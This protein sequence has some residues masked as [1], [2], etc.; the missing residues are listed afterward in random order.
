MDKAIPGNI[1]AEA[2]T[3]GAMLLDRDAIS[4]VATMLKPQ[5]FILEKHRWI[6]EAM[7]GVHQRRSEVDLQTVLEELRRH[8]RHTAVGDLAGLVDLTSAVPYSLHIEYYAGIVVEAATRRSII[9]AGGK[10]AA[11]GYEAERELSDVVA[12]CHVVLSDAIRTSV[13]TEAASAALVIDELM[14][15][16]D[17]D[18][19]PGCSSGLRDL[20]AKL[21]GF[22]PEDL[23]IIAARPSVGKSSLIAQIAVNI[24]K[25]GEP[26]MIF[27][28]EMG[29]KK[30]MQ[31]MVCLQTGYDLQKMALRKFGDGDLAM[32][33]ECA[34]L[35]RELP[36]YIEHKGGR[37]PETLRT[38]VLAHVMRHGRLAV[39]MVDYLQLMNG[40]AKYNG[41]RV[42]EV[43]EVS[44]Q[45]K[46]IAMETGIP[47]IALSQL[48]RAVENRAN[49]TPV[50]ADLRESGSIEQ[51]SDW[52]AFIT[53]TDTPTT[54]EIHIAKNRQGPLGIVP[55]Y[56][57]A[58]CSRWSDPERYKT[59]EGY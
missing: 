32:L 4:R 10:I 3:L 13:A 34:G 1:N 46:L 26:V 41:N 51:D 44:R 52:V 28:H 49:G 43:S 57:D 25:R 47:I 45:L 42:A 33:V 50:L 35:T 21:G 39:I 23:G 15:E 59:P 5:H 53:R 14:E 6:Y 19:T 8:D 20:D 11:L 36:L 7:L 30:I 48:N 56:F 2:A 55:L 40:D 38:Q 12:Q 27:S 16:W 9:Q 58:T 31:R 17:S 18:I 29:R 24:A 54:A 22:Q 37:T